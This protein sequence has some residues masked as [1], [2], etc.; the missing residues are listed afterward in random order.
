MSVSTFIRF[1]DEQGVIYY[2][3]PAQADLI[4]HFANATVKILEGNPFDGLK[5]SSAE[6]KVAKVG[7]QPRIQTKFLY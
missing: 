7:F 6:A 4:G 1:Q 5:R 2:G 3:E